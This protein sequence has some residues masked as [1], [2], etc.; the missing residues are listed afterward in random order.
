MAC[1]FSGGRFKVQV[2]RNDSSKDGDQVRKFSRIRQ[3]EG[4]KPLRQSSVQITSSLLGEDGDDLEDTQTL[5]LKH[6]RAA[7]TLLTNPLN[8]VVAV[9]LEAL[10]NKHEI[11]LPTSAMSSL[12]KLLSNAE[13][14]E[15]YNLLEDIYETL[16]YDCD[17]DVNAFFDHL[18]QEVIAWA[19]VGLLE[20]AFRC[21]GNDLTA[22]LTTLDGVND[23]VQHQS[24]SEAEAEFVCIATPEALE[25]HF[26]T[27]H[28]SIAYLLVGSLK[29]IA[30]QFYNDQADVY[31]LPDPYN[32]KFFRYRIT[33]ERYSERP[34]VADANDDSDVL[35]SAFRPLS[36]EATDLRMGVASFCKAF[37]WHFVVDRQLELVQLGVGF[38]R[39][40][41]HHL[42][43]HGREISTYFAF[44]RPHGVTL[45]FHE[46]LK[47]A[48]TPFI[49]TLQ[50]PHGIDKYPAEGLE[51]KGQM[52]HCPESDSILFVSSPFLN[53]LE[54]LTGRGLF[55]SDI[56]LHDATRDVILVGEQARA[57]DGLRR[58]MDKLKSSI[59]EANLAVDAEREKNVSLLHLIFPP[60]IAK[61]LWLGET[62]E[63]KTYPDVT[64]LFSDIVGFTAIC[65]TAT[66]MMVIN[67]LQNLYEQF[68][69]FCGQLDVYK[70]ET[71]GDAYCVACGLHRN[72]NTHAQQIAWMGLKMIQTCSHHLTHEGKPIKMRIGIH[73]GMVLAGVVGKKMPRYCLFG[74][75]VTLAN[76]FESTSEPLRVNVSPTTYLCLIQRSGF[77]L[78]PRTKDN[79]P[80][81]L[82]ASVSGTCYFLNGYQHDDVDAG[83]PLNVHIQAAITELGI[84]S[85]M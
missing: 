21:L 32:T 79:L 18:G 50:R 23:V 56:P 76:R 62:I 6:L 48:N 42:N 37:P 83:E 44:T 71:I 15:N 10:L 1:P 75:N 54:G 61:R 53:G 84:S 30:R 12:E 27:D 80:K 59:E 69:I 52:V 70:V 55:I 35:S 13:E 46:I 64:M 67:M 68:D 57:Q 28:P 45:T 16:N 5:N 11:P 17:V 74:H 4:D 9:A 29:G 49:L 20:R 73:T 81:G 33:P 26:T 58:R 72:T 2:T 31:I 41:G 7:V 65:A 22:F 8:E 40:F 39:I 36:A 19:C 82:P 60:D 43:R 66:P 78:E 77:I 3:D 14:E 34:D 51:M 85:N 47:R 38:M 24:G 25:L 63:A